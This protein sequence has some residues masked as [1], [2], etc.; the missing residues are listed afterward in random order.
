MDKIENI[1]KTKKVIRIPIK[2]TVIFIVIIL[3]LVILLFIFGIFRPHPILNNYNLPEMDK[4]V[5]SGAMMEP[6]YYPSNEGTPTVEDTREFLKTSYSAQIKTRK[7][8]DILR[9]VKSIISEM[10]GR[11]DNINESPKSGYIRFVVPKSN[12][13]NF[14]NE[15]DS[16]THE[17]LITENISST[18]LLNQ[19]Q[20]IEEQQQSANDL[21]AQLQKEQKDLI[22]KHTADLKKLQ[23]K[24]STLEK[25]L[26]DFT[27][28]LPPILTTEQIA[29]MESLKAE[30]NL[31]KQQIT[32]ENS[33][34][35]SA[36][37]IRKNNIAGVKT[38]IEDIQK[39]DTQF[40]NNIETVSGSISVSWISLWKLVKTFSPISPTLIIII[41][42]VVVWYFL[43]RKNYLPRVEFV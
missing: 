37:E 33:S 13:E 19:K 39:Q 35:N 10:D 3:V 34:F 23:N 29:Q 17:K 28:I 2:K 4:R 27:K 40:T 31:V 12:F 18:N 6:S 15:I 9:D 8:K 11:I 24:L 20:T 14:K 16:I 43:K 22:A 38:Q 26:E 36:N 41:L 7:V 32:S 21:L 5:Q 25:Q 30:I 42:L 1:E